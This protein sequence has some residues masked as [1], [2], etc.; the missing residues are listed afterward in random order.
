MLSWQQTQGPAP[1]RPLARHPLLLVAEQAGAKAAGSGTLVN[2]PWLVRVLGRS[3]GT[4]AGDRERSAGGAPKSPRAARFGPGNPLVVLV[5]GGKGGC[6]RTTFALDL[7]DAFCHLN[8]FRQVLLVD[9]DG[10]DPD[11]DLRV[12]A[13][14][15]G[16][17][18]MP[19]A[20]LNEL[21]LRFSE[22]HEGRLGIESCL[23]SGPGLGFQTL[24]APLTE[25]GRPGVGREHLDYLWEHFLAPRF[26]AVIVDGGPVT[27][28][29]GLLLEF[30][31]ER[32][33]RALVPVGPSEGHLR[34]CR[35]TIAGLGPRAGL[36][37]AD[38]LAV[39]GTD[40]R[41]VA[42][43]LQPKLAAEGLELEA[44]PWGGAKSALAEARHLPRAA[45]DRAAREASLSLAVRIVEQVALRDVVG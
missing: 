7:A 29:P 32:S 37:R 17:D 40:S 4:T 21:V 1:V 36:G 38:W 34:S 10:V 2:Q 15:A 42:R 18:L 35:R 6:G 45:L 13:F 23:W 3:L 16:R 25:S 26:D 11:I 44:V 33:A 43:S 5:V 39:I 30:F 8:D 28:A 27:P 31:A 41:H 24:L 19:S 20:R 9:A 12:G 14:A 22:L